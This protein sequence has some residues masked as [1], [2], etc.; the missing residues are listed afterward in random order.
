MTQIL[1]LHLWKWDVYWCQQQI[2]SCCVTSPFMDKNISKNV[3][4]WFLKCIRCVTSNL[5]GKAKINKIRHQLSR[6]ITLNMWTQVQQ[7]QHKA[8]P[9]KV[10]NTRTYSMFE[11][12]DKEANWG[13]KYTHKVISDRG[14]GEKKHRWAESNY[15]RT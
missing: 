7:I 12:H 11:N 3:Q 5:G 2:F 10:W 13:F 14:P 15:T 1:L 9:S 4:W 6:I 8:E